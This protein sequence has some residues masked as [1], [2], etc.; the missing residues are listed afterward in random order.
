MV[1]L[2]L[3]EYR[4]Q[5][6]KTMKTKL[7]NTVIA[8]FAAQGARFLKLDRSVGLWY[9][10][11]TKAAKERIGSAFRDASQPNKVKCMEKL[12]VRIANHQ[13][14]KRLTGL[15]LADH[16]PSGSGSH[17]TSSGVTGASDATRAY[18][19]V[20]AQGG[21]ATIMET[22]RQTRPIHHGRKDGSH[23]A[24]SS[25]PADVCH[26]VINS[27]NAASDAFLSLSSDI[28]SGQPL[29]TS[30]RELDSAI[31]AYD[32]PYSLLELWRPNDEMNSMASI[33]T[34]DEIDE[35][36]DDTIDEDHAGCGDPGHIPQR[37]RVFLSALDWTNLC[38]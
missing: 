2:Q 9:D 21:P 26:F 3:E 10:G 14:C 33:E 27:A 34:I 4:K 15:P 8:D 7:V 37:D 6:V 31:V 20:K 19:Q 25:R 30:K 23:C 29:D 28:A 12:K 36:V 35:F 32:E 13:D 17:H 11:G 16:S 18:T 5:T 38:L 22:R 24:L 1:A